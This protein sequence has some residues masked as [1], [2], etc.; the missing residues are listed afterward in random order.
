MNF[1]S[2]DR[3]LELS[4]HAIPLNDFALELRIHTQE[5]FRGNDL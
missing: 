1:D 3:V 5:Y 4:Y 2:K